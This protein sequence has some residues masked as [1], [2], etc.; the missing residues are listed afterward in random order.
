MAKVRKFMVNNSEV[1][2]MLTQSV[3]SDLSHHARSSESMFLSFSTSNHLLSP[4]IGYHGDPLPLEYVM[5][6]PTDLSQER[7]MQVHM[8]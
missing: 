7:L 1:F 4:S 5:D 6:M 3:T 8:H 2:N